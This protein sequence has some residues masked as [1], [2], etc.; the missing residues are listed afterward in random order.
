MMS[1]TQFKISQLQHE[2]NT[3]LLESLV[4]FIAAFFGIALLP[5]LLVRYV[6]A[7][8]PLLET[9]AALEIIPVAL[10]AIAMAYFVYSIVSNYIRYNRIKLMENEII[11]MASTCECGGDCNCGNSMDDIENTSIISTKKWL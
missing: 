3:R 4:V 11:D 1:S 6:Y 5:Q 8:Q 9:P 10:F 7:N 2:N